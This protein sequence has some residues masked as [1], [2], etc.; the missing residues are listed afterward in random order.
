[1]SPKSNKISLSI[2]VSIYNVEKNVR[3]CV[4]CIFLQ[5]LDEEIFEVILINDGTEDKSME[6]ISDIISSHSNII[7]LN[8][9]NQGLSIARNN[10]MAIAKGYYILMVDSDDLLIKNS[11][12]P[13]LAKAIETNVDIVV[14]EFT[15]IGSEEVEYHQPTNFNYKETNGRQLFLEGFK[16][17]RLEQII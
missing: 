14:A 1:M 12:K 2:I 3:A 6:M 10:G 7:V 17:L 5:E 9:Q 8:Q 13:L 4:E 16:K 15:E 11:L